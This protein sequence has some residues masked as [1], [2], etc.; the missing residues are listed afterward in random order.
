MGARQDT[1]ANSEEEG[2]PSPPAK[3]QRTDDSDAS[4]RAGQAAQ[5]GS[6]EQ[7]PPDIDESLYSR[8]L[9]VLG[10]DAM[11]RMAQSD[12]LIS[13][14]G[15]LGVEIAK[16]IILGGVRSVTI[17]DEALCT[18]ADLS[19][20]YYLSEQTVG[21][22]RADACQVLLGRLNQ[23]V[24]VKLHTKPLTEKFLKQFTV[25]VLTET[26]LETQQSIAAFTHENN[27]PLIVADT[28]GL[29]GQIFC[30][31]GDKFR[32]RDTNGEQP[33]SVMIQS[34]SKEGEVKTLGRVRHDFEDGDYV[35]FS[36][37]RGTPEIN[38]CPPMEV[39]VSC[40]HTFSVKLATKFGEYAI[41][42]VATEVKMPKDIKFKPLKESLVNPDFVA[43]ASATAHHPAQLHLGF[44][45]L[46]AF[47]K[48]HSRLPRPWNKDDAAVVVELA[49]EKNA[50]QATPLDEVDEKL[51]TTLSCVSA[52]SLCPV[53]AVIG[54]IAAQEVM[55]AC[56]GKFT[57]IQQWFYFDAFECLPQTGE[58]PEADAIAMEQTRYAAQ[59]R[60]LGTRVQSLL[61]AQNYFVVGAGAIGCELLKNF[62][63]MGVGV[64]KGCIHIADMDVIERSNLNRQFLFRSEDIGRMKSATAAEAVVQMNPELNITVHV[65]RVGPEMESVYN[66][67]FFESLDG[68]AN[69]LDNLDGRLYMDQRCV[70][71]CKPL[72]ESGTMGT[73]G[74]VQVVVPHLTE[75]YSCSQD[76]PE[77]SV[78]VCTIKNFPNAIEH[79]LQWARDEFEGLFRMSA[80][81]AV[82]YLRDP[83]FLP[84]ELRTS[85]LSQKVVLLEELKCILV[86]ERPR[87]FDECVDFARL[88]FQEQY[89]TRIKQ[90]LQAYPE[91][92]LTPSGMPF[93]S[94]RKR[95]P[96]PIEFDPNNTLHMDYIVAAANLRA[97][98]FGIP[99]NTDRDAIAQILEEVDVPAYDPQK[100]TQVAA[101]SNE[102]VVAPPDDNELLDK[103]LEEL[104][105]P[106]DLDDL[107]L[108][109]LEFEKD[110]DANFHMDFIVAASNLRAANYDIQPADRLKSKL[111]A[112]K[113]TPA[114]A[115]TTS[116]VAGL[117]CL[118]LYK[119]VQGHD[120]LEL[121]KNSFVN[122]ALPFVGFSEPIP[123][124]KK[125]FR[126]REFTFWD[127]LEIQGELTLV[128]FLDHFRRELQIE[129]V[130]LSEG[131]RMLYDAYAPPPRSRLNLAVSKILE[132]VSKTEIDSSKRALM[133]QLMGRDV[134]SGEEVEL[135]D[136]RYVLSK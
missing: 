108:T 3:R 45:A 17:H 95:C 101:N 52:G 38:N 46:H 12:V 124:A 133:L 81:N 120:R 70:W 48:L 24:Q 30:D 103:L 73:K 109:A 4:E 84:E 61:M 93:W 19:S 71:H 2:D 29:A 125:K 15:G 89:N 77:T 72:L 102:P 87:V 56:S 134:N 116:L 10:H 75:S 123:A 44:Q 63:M 58:V 51:L 114:I 69:A 92:K 112:G 55:K 40:E 18:M 68:V 1:M 74:N 83:N 16:N 76:P 132:D 22:N 11:I 66:D 90:L 119:L 110:D 79:T 130:Y 47:Q 78:P 23:Y 9:Y 82:E 128:E 28:R 65:D 36:E 105:D 117:A 35:T 115:T 121:Y 57:P 106:E 21:H 42:G 7:K 98:M 91:E 126:N 31:F 107:T 49:K 50:L 59:A 8:Q 20:Q 127:C 136:V 94:G 27:I 60:V 13:G 122:L 97:T 129:I 96:H 53:Q 26:P 85:Q 5:S 34:I 6:S 62:A 14:M 88:R 37:V 100:N 25:V 67:D 64:A 43:S 32:V 41:G 33:R 113:I 131:A 111:I 86:D 104:P 118:E 80:V 54:S 135:P 99:H 39:K